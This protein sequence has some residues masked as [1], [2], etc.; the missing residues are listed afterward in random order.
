MNFKYKCYLQRFFSAV[1]EGEKLNYLF[2][3]YVS[4]SLPSSNKRFL[5]KV[6]DAV[7]HHN[8]FKQYN[9][10][11][12]FS[13]RYYEFG[14]GWT[15]VIPL[16]MSFL[17]F[18]IYCVDIRKLIIPEL[19]QDS[20]KKFKQNSSVLPFDI[21]GKK[22]AEAPSKKILKYLDDTFQLKYEAPQDARATRFED[23]T[24]DFMSSSVT[25]EHI[26]ENDNLLILKEC[27]RIL[28]KG[29]ILS[30][31]IDYKDHWSYFDKSISI[32]NFLQY[33]EQDWKKYN[34][35]LHYQN[36]MRHSDYMR[37][38]NQSGFEVVKEVPFLPS[39]EDKKKL[40]ATKL[41][42]HF[43]NYTFDDLGI[44]GSEIVLRK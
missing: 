3:R 36:R 31:K 43:Q 30:V 10:L 26:P 44:R 12:D 5:E 8:N 41:D 17:D 37:I 15:L 25:M 33:S 22:F 16:A 13:N 42:K 18:E 35:S 4:K 11:K 6:G 24:F 23:N 21:S 32:Y 2:Q 14:A 40:A 9:Q 27:H 7:N 19:I 38:I 39:E 1:P 28:N 20:I 34:P 29:G